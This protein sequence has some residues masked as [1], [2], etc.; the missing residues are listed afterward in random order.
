MT[1]ADGGNGATPARGGIIEDFVAVF[2]SPKALF[3]RYRGGNFVRPALIAM[4]LGGVMVI[5]SLNLILPY[6]EAEAMRAVRQSGQAMPEGAMAAISTTMKITTIVGAVIG[7]WLI[8]ILG[9]VGVFIAARIVGARLTFKQSATVSAWSYIPAAVLGT[10]VL[11]I[12]GALVDSSAIR[13]I[14]DG[15]LGVGRFMDPA[16]VSPVILALVQRLDL[17]GIWGLV[18]TAIGISVIARKDM[19]TAVMAAVIS[20][21]IG[22]LFTIVPALLR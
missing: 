17:F 2:T 1:E 6:F 5:A 21:A 7:P 16:T 22:S 12:Q 3:D 18:L 11:A 20:F 15:Q 4:V 13:G 14:T 8:A 10:V 9:G 19:T